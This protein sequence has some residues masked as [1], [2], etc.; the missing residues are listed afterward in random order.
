MQVTAEVV[1]HVD[2]RDTVRAVEGKA[3]DIHK[4]EGV[5]HQLGLEENQQVDQIVRKASTAAGREAFEGIAEERVAAKLED[6][7]LVELLGMEA[8]LVL[9]TA[10][11]QDSEDTGR[12]AVEEDS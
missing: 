8:C 7:K 5:V 3:E 9:G 11:Q 2:S 12:K 1:D 10:V 4:V 6:S